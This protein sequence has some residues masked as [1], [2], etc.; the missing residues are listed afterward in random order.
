MSFVED[1]FFFVVAFFDLDDFMAFDD[2]IDFE[3]FMAFD[4]LAFEDDFFIFFFGIFLVIVESFLVLVGPSPAYAI[5]PNAAKEAMR[6]ITKN[7]FIL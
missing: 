1:G 2:F 6:I 4:D 7:F 3:D 5:D